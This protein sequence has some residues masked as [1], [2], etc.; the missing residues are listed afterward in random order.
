M[1]EPVAALGCYPSGGFVVPLNLNQAAHREKGWPS[2]PGCPTVQ[3]VASVKVKGLAACSWG[4]PRA[5]V[6]GA[7]QASWRGFLSRLQAQPSNNGRDSGIRKSKEK[8][9]N[10]VLRVGGLRNSVWNLSS[11]GGPACGLCGPGVRGPALSLAQ[12]S[13]QACLPPARLLHAVSA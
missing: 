5:T 3:A 7:G 8:G 12:G 9:Q 2:R 1:N 4:S 13:L 10:K 6:L 11:D